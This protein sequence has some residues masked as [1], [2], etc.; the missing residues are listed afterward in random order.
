MDKKMLANTA[1]KHSDARDIHDTEA[2][3][4]AAGRAVLA[5]HEE[6]YESVWDEQHEAD[7]HAADRAVLA[8]H[9]EGHESVW[10]EQQVWDA[11]VQTILKTRRLTT[12][13]L[14]TRLSPYRVRITNQL[15]ANETR[16]EARVQL[17]ALEALAQP[18]TALVHRILGPLVHA[19]GE[20][21]PQPASRS[22]E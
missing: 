11:L 10:V 9:E 2:D 21:A 5:A 16:K 15:G 14:D 1:L 22:M 8:L 13:T 20:K 12:S 17:H 19:P 7:L 6:D 18:H 3:L 4:H